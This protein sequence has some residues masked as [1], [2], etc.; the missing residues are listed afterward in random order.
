MDKN[1]TKSLLLL[2][3]IVFIF[4]FTGILGKLITLPATQLVWL[5]MLIGFFGIGLYMLISKNKFSVSKKQFWQYLGVGVI[6]AMHWIAFFESIKVSTISI[7]LVCLSTATLFT[8][9]L[10][11]LLFGRKIKGYE[12]MLGIVVII[13]LF[14]I[15]KFEFQYKWGILLS[16]VCAFLA[17]LFNVINGRL[18]KNES[19]ST[20]SFYEMLGGSIILTLFFG[21]SQPEMFQLSNISNSDWGFLLLLGIVCTSFAFVAGVLIM[22][23]I[24][25]FTVALSINLEPIYGILLALIIFGEEEKM[26]SGFYLGAGI[27]LSAVIGNAYLKRRER[28]LKLKLNSSIP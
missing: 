12:I 8:A 26:S 28:K 15:F 5:R 25:P 10:E 11:P 18:T 17:S 24:T 14:A 20:I 3:L 1:Q 23:Q 13:G 9:L 2:H 19:P 16:V 4:G 27:I 6:I 7:A 22:R 21:L